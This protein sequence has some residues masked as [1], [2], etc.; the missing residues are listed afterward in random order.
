MNIV[1]YMLRTLSLAFQGGRVDMTTALLVLYTFS[2]TFSKARMFS[3][4]QQKRKSSTHHHA[5]I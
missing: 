2:K 5:P 1:L 4:E 3:F